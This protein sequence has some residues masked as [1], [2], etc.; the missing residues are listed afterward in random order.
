MTQVPKS[1]RSSRE[2]TATSSPNRSNIRKSVT[3]SPVYYE[4]AASY[5]CDDSWYYWRG[6]AWGMY[7]S[8][9]VFLRDYRGHHDFSRQ[10]YG[11]GR[12]AGGASLG[13]GR[14]AVGHRIGLK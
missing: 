5:Y 4:G 1:R 7:S 10:Y 8:E 6:G 2:S 3:I 12:P 11:R 9:P 14:E 13:A